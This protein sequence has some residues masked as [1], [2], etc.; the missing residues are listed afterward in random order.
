MQDRQ[1]QPTKERENNHPRKIQILVYFPKITRRI[2]TLDL[3]DP[4]VEKPVPMETVPET[5]RNPQVF[6]HPEKEIDTV[7]MRMVLTIWRR[8]CSVVQVPVIIRHILVRQFHHLFPQLALNAGFAILIAKAANAY[9]CT[10]RKY[11]ANKNP[12]RRNAL[13][14]IV[15]ENNQKANTKKKRSTARIGK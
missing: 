3:F 9:K 11:K 10:G 5:C 8:V 1:H 7:G 2:E 13:M 12:Y 14:Q 15:I 6:E 4:L